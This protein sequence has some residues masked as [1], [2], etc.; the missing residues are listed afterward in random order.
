MD[1]KQAFLAEYKAL[2]E[3]HGLYLHPN[4]YDVLQVSALDGGD[5]LDRL[6]DEE[7]AEAEAEGR[8]LYRQALGEFIA[9]IDRGPRLE[10]RTGGGDFVATTAVR[11]TTV[12]IGLP[13]NFSQAF[14]DYQNAT[15]P[16]IIKDTKITD[17]LD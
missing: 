12:A 8:K 2:C 4:M 13:V 17:P 1:K 16:K 9:E 5:P 11:G 10:L 15:D 3:A 6:E 7:D 14:T